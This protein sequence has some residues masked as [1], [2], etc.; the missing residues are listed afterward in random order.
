M[1]K[2][3]ITIALLIC[4]SGTADAKGSY[5]CP[6]PCPV[7]GNSTGVGSVENVALHPVAA[8]PNSRHKHAAKHR[9]SR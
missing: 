6:R 4:V 1:R 8:R 3:L 7:G 2:Y 5:N 9:A